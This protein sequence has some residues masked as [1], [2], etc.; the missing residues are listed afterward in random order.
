[1]TYVEMAEQ[2]RPATVKTL[3]IGESPPYT[4]A[5]DIRQVPY[6]YNTKF[7]DNQR[8]SLLRETAKVVLNRHVAIYSERQ[9]HE[10]LSGL[11]G[12]GVFLIDAVERPINDLKG[13][14][15]QEAIRKEIPNLL[16]RVNA[17]KPERIIVVLTSVY[18]LIYPA[19]QSEGLPLVPIRVP[20][21]WAA[22]P[23]GEGYKDILG[24]ALCYQFE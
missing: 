16:L 5:L 20:S 8:D 21:P 1:M 11:K 6:F 24:D 13:R 22:K 14:R 12:K 15:R 7:V 19:L 2:Y 3:L 9:K 18:D 23:M 17:V 4:E 10:V